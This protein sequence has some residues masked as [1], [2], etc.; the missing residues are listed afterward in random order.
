MLLKTQHLACVGR[1]L[2]L[3]DSSKACGTR[4]EYMVLLLRQ[5]ALGVRL[6]G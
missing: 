2:S 5:V 3:Y 6:A 4:F 1:M